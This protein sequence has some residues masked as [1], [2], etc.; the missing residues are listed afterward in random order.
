[1]HELNRIWAFSLDENHFE[2]N[3]VMTLTFE[4]ENGNHTYLIELWYILYL[5]TKYDGCNLKAVYVANLYI[6]LLQRRKN[7]NDLWWP[8]HWRYGHQKIC[9]I[10]GV[11]LTFGPKMKLIRPLVSEE[12]VKRDID[13]QTG[14][15]YD[16]IDDVMCCTVQLNRNILNT[17]WIFQFRWLI[18]PIWL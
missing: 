4:L 6:T 14:S 7:F 16:N 1:M 17:R 18:N 15:R 2:I 12:Y 5:N 8:W 13:R 3:K 10:P 9:T 11:C